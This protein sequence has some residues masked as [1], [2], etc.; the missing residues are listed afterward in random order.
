LDPHGKLKNQAAVE[1]KTTIVSFSW[2]D[3]SL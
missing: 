2:L 1:P 3:F